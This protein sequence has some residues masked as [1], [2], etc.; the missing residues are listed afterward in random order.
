MTCSICFET[1]SDVKG[2]GCIDEQMWAVFKNS[3]MYTCSTEK[4]KVSVCFYCMEKLLPDISVPYK[5]T[6]CRLT[7]WHIIHKYIVLTEL[8]FMTSGTVKCKEYIT[9]I[10]PAFHLR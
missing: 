6:H 10:R 5:C 4:C 3:Q 8:M 7:D 9:N 1:G 2:V